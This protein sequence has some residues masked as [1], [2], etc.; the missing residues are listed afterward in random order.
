MTRRVIRYELVSPNVTRTDAM[1][2]AFQCNF[3]HARAY[4]PEETGLHPVL[5]EM[6]DGRCHRASSRSAEE[7]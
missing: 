4:T 5:E 3:S 1:A 6:K 2:I 7:R